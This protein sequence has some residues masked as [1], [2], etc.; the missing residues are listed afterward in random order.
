M[1]L[2]LHDKAFLCYGIHTVF[3]VIDG[4]HGIQ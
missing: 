2:S 1:V 3:T 4:K